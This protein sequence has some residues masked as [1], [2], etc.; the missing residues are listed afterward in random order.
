MM[1][2]ISLCLG[3][4]L[5]AAPA[6]AENDPVELVRETT[7]MLF[8]LVEENREQYEENPNLLRAELIEILQ[9]RTDMIHSARLI[10]GRHGRQ[11]ER[12]QIEAFAKA[13]SDLLMGRYATGLL[14]FRSREQVDI[15][16]LAGDNNERMTRVRT[17]IRL[18]TG[19]RAPV[20]YV[21]RKSDGEWKVFD[22]I[23]E[24]ISY[25]ATFRNQIGEEI[26]R[27][28]FDR[29]LNRLQAGEIEVA[30]DLN[31]NGN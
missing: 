14:E 13:V 31:N 18:D 5:F 10:L 1:R 22:V 17:R 19:N 2:L 20:D 9:P 15:L 6:L 4:A 23:I 16:P 30:I 11:L 25:V 26:R 27:D 28:G 29:M 7:T 3:L 21:L 12:D 24:G 8:H